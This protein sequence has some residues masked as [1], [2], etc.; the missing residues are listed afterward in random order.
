MGGNLSV[1]KVN[2]RGWEFGIITWSMVG[3]GPWPLGHVD[4]WK[5]MGLIRPMRDVCEIR[6][7]CIELLMGY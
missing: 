1:V 7:M 3:F 6:A 2:L 4:G 5:W